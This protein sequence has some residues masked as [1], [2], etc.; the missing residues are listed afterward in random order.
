MRIVL[1]VLSTVL[2]ICS[3]KDSCQNDV[4]LSENRVEVKINRID[5]KLR[6]VKTIE[7]VTE[8]LEQNKAYQEFIIPRG[9]S[10]NEVVYRLF[11]LGTDTSFNILYH[12]VDSVYADLDVL[13]TDLSDLFSHVSYY[14]PKWE[15]PEVITM[16]SGFGGYDIAQTNEIVVI[17]LDYFLG[18][19]AKFVDQTF[20][21]YI[22]KYYTPEQ[23]PYKVAMNLSKPFNAFDPKD[24]SVLAHMIYYGK[25]YYFTQ[26]M[27]PCSSD[28]VICEY[29][30][31]EIGLLQDDPAYVWAHFVQ[32]KLFYNADR[33][34][35]QKYIDD[36]PK[37]F[38][39]GEN[40]PGRVGRWLGFEVV[41]SYMKTHPEVSLKMLMEMTDAKKIFNDS[42][43]HPKN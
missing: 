21:G 23:L 22:L 19:N 1:V 32:N 5:Q 17:G 37:T 28:S 9:M 35:I 18:P 34:A 16:V 29:S 33:K 42:Q 24:Q 20:P 4:D 11:Q 14:Y 7:K 25:A 41:K 40:C 43:Y 39:I 27:I 13:E 26:Q 12:E 38:E 3:C 15:S 10:E 30:P 2:F 8:L 6:S 31:T 36:R